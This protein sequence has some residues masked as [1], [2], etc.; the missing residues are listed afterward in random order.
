M[1]VITTTSSSSLTDGENVGYADVGEYVGIIVSTG[2]TGLSVSKSEGLYVGSEY[3]GLKLGNIVVALGDGLFVVASVVG[4]QV[5][6]YVDGGCGI[7]S[8]SIVV[9]M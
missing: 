8:G 7:S 4:D 9:G 1:S 2:F 5:G 3:V 6:K